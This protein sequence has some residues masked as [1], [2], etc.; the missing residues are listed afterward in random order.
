L[1]D[2]NVIELSNTSKAKKLC[3]RCG[4]PGS[5]PYQRWVRNS[6]HKRY[7]PYS[8]FAHKH[9][10]TI[11]WCYLSKVKA[12]RL[13]NTELGKVPRCSTSQLSNTVTQTEAVP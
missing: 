12:S 11:K 1:L 13:D 7:E 2:N 6:R 3:P 10:K 8:Y 9:G 4:L 5:G